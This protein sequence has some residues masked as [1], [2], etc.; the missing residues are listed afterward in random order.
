MKHIAETMVQTLRQELGLGGGGGSVTGTGGVGASVIDGLAGGIRGRLP[1]LDAS[2]RSAAGHVNSALTH[3]ATG[4]GS[5][6]DIVI[7]QH[8]EVTG[9]D[10]RQLFKVTQPQALRVSRRNGANNL[11]LRR[12]RGG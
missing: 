3:A 10:A 8:I 4:G 1:T 6:G 9:P 11:E 7:H 2:L 12:G 5:G